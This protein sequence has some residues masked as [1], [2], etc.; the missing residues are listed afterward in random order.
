MTADV[1]TAQQAADLDIARQ[2]VAAG[3]PVFICR[4]DP[5]GKGHSNSGYWFPKAWEQTRPDPAIIDSWRPGMALGAVMGCG[6]DLLDLDPRNGADLGALNGA[7]PKS[8][9]AA[10]TPSAGVHS[11]IASV[12]EHS[13]DK[14]ADGIDYKGGAPDGE[15]RG[16]AFIAPTVK[17]SKVTGEPAPYRWVTRRTWPPPWPAM[18]GREFA[19]LVREA[20]ANGSGPR[21]R[22]QGGGDGGGGQDGELSAMCLDLA[23]EGLSDDEIKARWRARADSLPLL[24]PSEPWTD[25]DFTRHMRSARRKYNAFVERTSY[26]GHGQLVPAIAG[27]VAETPF[28]FDPQVSGDQHL[29][30]ACLRAVQPMARY[31]ADAGLWLWRNS[32]ERW[33]AVSGDSAPAIITILTDYMP[34]G[35]HPEQAGKTP[36]GDL[37]GDRPVQA[38]GA[39]AVG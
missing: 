20:H 25:T 38:A 16:F 27:A 37:R 36:D 8:Y 31:A 7:L 39:A 18:T 21:S 17:K 28:V 13:R 35:I 1:L 33:E 3:I 23:H 15:G 26:P 11:F 5:A 6:L 2:L 4:P 29:A 22:G 19:A 32:G 10:S 14:L 24:R 30:D 9:G 34:K 12:G